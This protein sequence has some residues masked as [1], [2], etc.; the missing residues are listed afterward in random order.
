[1]YT[2]QLDDVGLQF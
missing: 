1:M 2:L